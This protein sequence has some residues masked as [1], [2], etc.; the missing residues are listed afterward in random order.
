MDRQLLKEISRLQTIMGVQSRTKQLISE[1]WKNAIGAIADVVGLFNRI[2]FEDIV[3]ITPKTG[4]ARIDWTKVKSLNL[5]EEASDLLRLFDDELK[6]SEDIVGTPPRWKKNMGDLTQ[7]FERADDLLADMISK[8]T[9]SADVIRGINRMKAAGRPS[10]FVEQVADVDDFWVILQGRLS[11]T[12]QPLNKKTVASVLDLP[13]NSTA[14]DDV[15]DELLLYER[16]DD[17]IADLNKT[18]RIIDDIVGG[19]GNNTWKQRNNYKNR[20][21]CGRSRKIW[22]IWETH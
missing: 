20:R 3:K 10:K 4:Y 21:R 6:V 12:G 14:V 17:L 7:T 11:N 2:N 15:F 8:G 5:S 19:G 18:N 13:P 22:W 16:T 1:Q 9:S